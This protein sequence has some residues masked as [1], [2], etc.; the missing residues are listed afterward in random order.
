MA[1]KIADPIQKFMAPGPMPNGLR[2]ADD[3]L[4]YIDQSDDHI[5]K[6]NWQT[7]E[8]ISEA[9]TESVHSG[10]ITVSDDGN[11]WV[12]SAYTCEIFCVDRET[13]D[14]IEKFPSPGAG[15][16][17]TFEHLEPSAGRVAEP[18]GDHG[19][20]WRDGHIYIASPPSQHIHVVEAATWKEVH[21]FKTP[22]YRPHGIAFAE[23]EG[24]MWV[25]DTSFG[26]VSRL[27][28]EDGRCYDVFRVPHP[29]QVHGMT[30]KDNQLWYTDD[31]GP[32]GVLSVSMEPD[33]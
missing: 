22:G 18:T 12:S 9:P 32:I 1:Y 16:I 15:V 30:I 2:A 17:S 26:V 8:A 14:T 3:G 10:G 25:S 33:F 5:A 4:W 27:R 20:E 28:I 23:E 7:G 21:R 29:L 11:V 13:G 24:H 19:L 6:L 31:R